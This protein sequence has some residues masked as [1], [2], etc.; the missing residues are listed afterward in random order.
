[1]AVETVYEIL[2]ELAR[3]ALSAFVGA[4]AYWYF[5]GRKVRQ[6]RQIKDLKERLDEF[7]S[8]LLFHFENMKSW[9]IWLGEPDKYEFSLQELQNKFNET[10]QIM[11]SKMRLA[12]TEIRRL[13]FDWQPSAVP[14]HPS[15]KRDEFLK[16]SHRLHE[17]IKSEYE[18]LDNEL[19]KLLERED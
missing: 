17:A 13:W 2:I 6:E 8:P 16:R 3:V 15:W 11:K 12:T 10:T 4:F 18:K 14:S 7:Y 1:M 5:E 19:D 9:A